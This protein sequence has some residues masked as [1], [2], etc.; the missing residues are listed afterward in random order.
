MTDIRENK[1]DPVPPTHLFWK[2]QV[3]RQSNG[4][5]RVHAWQGYRVIIKSDL[6]FKQVEHFN[7]DNEWKKDTPRLSRLKR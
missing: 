7:A 4:L 6:M 1:A 5:Y 2:V 3:R